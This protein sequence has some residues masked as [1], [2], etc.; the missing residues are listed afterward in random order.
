MNNECLIDPNAAE[1]YFEYNSGRP[2]KF[3]EKLAESHFGAKQV[4]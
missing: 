3:L 1:S 2:A 4:F